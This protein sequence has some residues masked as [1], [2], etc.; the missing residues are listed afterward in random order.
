MNDDH[1]NANPERTDARTPPTFSATSSPRM[2]APRS[3]ATRKSR[4]AFLPSPTAIS[5]S[6]TP[7]PSAS[8]SASPTSSAARPT[9]ASTTP[10]PKK[11]S[12]STST[13]SGR[14]ALARLR[15]GAALLRLRLLRPALRVGFAA[16]QGRK[17]VRRRP[18]GRR[19]PPVPRHPDRARAKTAPI[20]I[21]QSKKIST[22]SSA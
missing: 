4:R 3:T 10:I 8:I 14:R 19:D 22:S 18:H 13:P 16:R 1:S 9:C 21:G 7:R 12:R 20:A 15:L 11:K 2:C 17:S 5:T 6:A